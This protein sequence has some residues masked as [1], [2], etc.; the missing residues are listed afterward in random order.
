MDF[1]QFD[2]A[3]TDFAYD[4]LAYQRYVA[5]A[6]STLRERE[7]YLLYEPKIRFQPEGDDVLVRLPELEIRATDAGTFAYHA[8][9]Q[10]SIALPGITA[11]KARKIL[12]GLDGARTLLGL[13]L[14]TRTTDKELDSFL[15]ATFGKVVFA[16]RT[17]ERFEARLSG[18][19]LVR[20][21]GSPYEIRRA[22]WSNMADCRER[23]SR[24][25]FACDD[26][27]SWIAELRRLHVIALMGAD[28]R[29]F[30]RPQSPLAARD[31]R[32]GSLYLTPTRMQ[33]QH[34]VT[35]LLEGPR[36][37]APMVGGR[38]FH[39]ALA[40][41]LA[42]PDAVLPHRTLVDASGNHWGTLCLGFARGDAAPSCWFCPPRP[43]T[44]AHWTC[45]YDAY[46]ASLSPAESGDPPGVAA[47]R[48]RVGS[49]AD[50]H[51]YFIRSHPFRCANQSLGMNLVNALLAH[52]GGAG[53]PHLLLD[54]WAL[55]LSR[56]A[57][58]RLFARVIQQY[59]L[60]TTTTLERWRSLAEMR[61]RFDSFVNRLDQCPSLQEAS[62]LI[63]REAS[64]AQLA[65]LRDSEV[66]R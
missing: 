51:W 12:E 53:I 52:Q 39:T 65:L 21:V 49:T 30:Y 48:T 40:N 47:H 17:L 64:N 61:Q 20:F 11:E 10:T 43:M 57:Y 32:P 5:E 4:L 60:G 23:I 2:L 31:P 22:Y 37:S 8:D 50:F 13:L 34:G 45:L 18:T 24:S 36:V 44:R 35:L 9:T 38:N 28:A 58:R 25:L 59:A 42:D 27:E 46:R 7:A 19:E 1:A 41:S 54:Q 55:R 66:P 16:P 63:E 29:T 26:L 6:Y 33:Q 56:D 14:A 15:A 62:K 3:T